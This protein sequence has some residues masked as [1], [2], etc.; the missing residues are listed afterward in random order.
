MIGSAIAGW[1]LFVIGVVMY[2]VAI[3][4]RVRKMFGPGEE[5]SLVA[6]KETAEAVAKL[7]EAFAKFS[8]DIQFLLLASGCLIAGIYLLQNRPF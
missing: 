8:E 7:A 1:I 2:L 6:I 5:E 4:E 3:I